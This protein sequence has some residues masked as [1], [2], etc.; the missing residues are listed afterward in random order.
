MNFLEK[1]LYV[2]PESRVPDFYFS[3]VAIV[4][5]RIT[6]EYQILPLICRKQELR[7]EK[8]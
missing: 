4:A 5:G 7:E 1:S 8:L 6:R 3:L 2:I